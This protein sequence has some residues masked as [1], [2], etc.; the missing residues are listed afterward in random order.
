M[1]GR[2]HIVVIR[3]LVLGVLILAASSLAQERAPI[4]EQIAKT[5]GLDSFG[6]I[7]QIRYTF[8]A[9]GVLNVSRSWVWEPK[10]DQVS[11]DG[12]DKAGNPVRVTYRRSQ[13]SSQSAVVK[14][15]IDP[16]FIN[17]QYWLLF[18]FHLSWDSS[19]K[20]EDTGEHKLA[21]G[22]G[23]A[24]R[25]VVTYPSDGGY[26]PGDTWDLFVGK[27]NRIQEWIYHRAGGAKPTGFWSWQDYKKAGP[28]LVSLDH[29]GK[30][31]F[32]P[33][34]QKPLPGGKPVRI[35][36]SDVAVKLAG[37]NTWVKAQ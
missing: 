19:A 21:M 11:Y 20:V 30:L 29:H 23:S 31:F 17:D 34:S 28:L 33:G 6:Q 4:A 15:E 36:F 26:T 12:K 32:L 16:A 10:T 2:S 1:I 9:E 8:N 5:Y 18:A 35:F 13:V 25:L 22:T 37:S 7:E 3:L 27:D 24:K 14:D